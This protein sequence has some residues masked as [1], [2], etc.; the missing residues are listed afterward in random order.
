MTFHFC[1]HAYLDPLPGWC[2]MLLVYYIGISYTYSGLSK[3][4]FSGFSWA[5][6]SSLMMWVEAWATGRE[7]PLYELLTNHHWLARMLQTT[8]LVAE[9]FAILMLFIPRLR[10]VL[11]LIFVGF[12]LSIELLFDFGFFANIFL[13]TYILIVCF[14]IPEY[15]IG[16]LQFF[17]ELLS[18]GQTSLFPGPEP[19]ISTNLP[20]TV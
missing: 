11:G 18:G 6:G 16:G 3:L 13:D 19:K 12:H 2:F 1:D 8:T 20:G 4:Y 5:D 10:P 9:L 17:R 15:R 14:V 7:N